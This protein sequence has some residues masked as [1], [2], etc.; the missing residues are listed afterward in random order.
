MCVCVCVCVC[1]FMR[2][3]YRTECRKL[4]YVEILRKE[5]QKREKN[6]SFHHYMNLVLINARGR[7]ISHS[8]FLIL[9]HRETSIKNNKII[10]KSAF[11]DHTKVNRL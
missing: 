1:V 11:S 4:I 2:V 10:I 5:R 7:Y 6:P 9:L 3:I 8:H